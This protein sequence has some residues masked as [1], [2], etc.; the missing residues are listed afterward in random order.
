MVVIA[1]PA[2]MLLFHR[3]EAYYAEVGREL[4]LGR[5]PPQPSQRDSIVIVPTST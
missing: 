3:T 1:V 4:K 5:T 2:M